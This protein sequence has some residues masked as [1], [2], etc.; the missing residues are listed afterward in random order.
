[1]RTKVFAHKGWVGIESDVNAE[2]ILNRPLD[3]GQLGFV[4]DANFVDITPEALELLKQVPGSGDDIGEVDI[5]E[6]NGKKV[7]FM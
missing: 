1:M 7:L 6:S 3:K 5:I 4:L 2:G